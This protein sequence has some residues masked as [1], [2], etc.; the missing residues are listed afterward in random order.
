M[1]LNVSVIN[2][3]KT[4]KVEFKLESEAVIDKLTKLIE[5]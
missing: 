3:I 5:F 4:R 1:F 2:K